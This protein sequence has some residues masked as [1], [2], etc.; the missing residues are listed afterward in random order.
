MSRIP[1]PV[2]PSS[3]GGLIFVLL[4]RRSS[5]HPAPPVPPPTPPHS[6]APA[7]AEYSRS[8]FHNGIATENVVYSARV[9]SRMKG[10]WTFLA[11][12][13]PRAL[14]AGK[15]SAIGA[16]VRPQSGG[17]QCLS[18]LVGALLTRFKALPY[19]LAKCPEM[20][21]RRAALPCYTG[22]RFVQCVPDLQGVP[23]GLMAPFQIT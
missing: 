15:N 4:G 20:R 14:D 7:I 19:P 5:T 13:I 8:L 17:G 12:S 21:S 9:P 10:L 6:Q 23:K 2:V 22:A 11:L 18:F 3:P 1:R 16:G